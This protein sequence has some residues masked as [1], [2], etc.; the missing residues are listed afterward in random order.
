M[1]ADELLRRKKCGGSFAPLSTS[2][3]TST[4]I[5]P[6]DEHVRRLIDTL[7][8]GRLRTPFPFALGVRAP[9]KGMCS[10]VSRHWSEYIAERQLAQR[11]AEAKA[12]D[13]ARAV[14]P[15]GPSPATFTFGLSPVELGPSVADFDALSDP[16]IEDAS[17][18]FY[19]MVG[20][21]S[22]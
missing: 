17:A 20:G 15:S 18:N 11:Q 2:T 21:P 12:G 14:V 6:R 19:A 5:R 22:F 1:G 3:G 10:S 16:G 8:T 7:A 13:G 4:A 9:S